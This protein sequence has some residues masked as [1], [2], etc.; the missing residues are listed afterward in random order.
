MKYPAMGSNP[1]NAVSISALS[2]GV[3]FADALN[4][5]DDNQMTDCKNVW[6]KDGVLKTRPG[7]KNLDRFNENETADGEDG[8]DVEIY[9]TDI[10]NFVDGKKHTF[11]IKKFKQSSLNLES[12]EMEIHR[13][14]A[15]VIML[16]ENGKEKELSVNCNDVWDYE[17]LYSDMPTKP[18]GEGLYLALSRRIRT[19]DYDTNK[20]LAERKIVEL[21]ELVDNSFEILEDTEYYSPA[22]L[23]NGKGESYSTLPA[24]EQVKYASSS[25]FE[26]YSEFYNVWHDFYFTTDGVST[27]F[28]LP[29]DFGF[30]KMKIE[31]TN[32]RTSQTHK[33]EVFD[34]GNPHHPA[35][36]EQEFENYV[37][38]K[39]QSSKV[40]NIIPK[41][42]KPVLPSSLGFLANNLKISVKRYMPQQE[43]ENGIGSFDVFYSSDL[44]FDNSNLYGATIST[45]FGGSAE[46]IHGGTRIFLSGIKDKINQNMI[47][48]SDLNNPTYFSENN[49][50]HV[51]EGTQS[52]TALKKQDDMLVIFK[53]N[54]LFYTTYV[55]GETYTAD[56]VIAGKVVD[57]TTL[58]AVF[59]I[60]Q[61]HSEI[62][63]D[64]P[65]SIQLCG[66]RLV[67]ACKDG[68]IYSLKSANQ[69]ST[70]NVA[71]LSALI[72]QKISAVPS[73]DFNAVF[74]GIHNG[75][76]LLMLGKHVFVLDFDH[77]YFNSLPS[78]SDT[79]KAQ[80]K[81]V[82]YYWEFPIMEDSIFTM[83][84]SVYNRCY[85]FNVSAFY[86][87]SGGTQEVQYNIFEL[88]EGL[89]ADDC[90]KQT[91]AINPS[92][93]VSLDIV[94]IPIESVIQTKMFDFGAMDRFKSIEQMYVGF[95][96]VEGET[97][98]QYLTDRG[99]LDK[100][101]V[102]ISSNGDMQSPQFIKTKRFLP[103]I[104]RA[105]RFGVR[106]TAKGR[107][108]ISGVLIK[109]KYM[110]LTR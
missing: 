19:R 109:Y 77:Y 107:V 31:Y 69:Y 20:I 30:C 87:I 54:E 100:G 106:F 38:K 32:H 40:I 82:W 96:E 29:S 23:I 57:V 12:G 44:S 103:G 37:I 51:G 102:E 4:L 22:V 67:W 21:Y 92:D 35:D 47:G 94:P 33:S 99:T 6:Y 56:D 10:V 2:G 101:V 8:G 1:R 45:S 9:S 79:Q 71:A 104:K 61:I 73:E 17:V 41:E 110:G 81:L 74:S 70:T 60:T 59:P 36:V 15:K 25:L 68:H 83:F 90:L 66:N 43:Y 105:L 97:S 76:Y 75:H 42:G 13:I 53:E 88:I 16:S 91:K 89:L 58:S 65:G 49:N 86:P 11:V 24:A 5:V 34:T 78:Y 62:G 64:L 18:N 85:V 48:W 52:I 7:I 28:V 39:A 26:G 80:R 72:D 14:D 46:G 93:R 3:N 27:A 55:K 63:C 50:A 98:V 108:A 95:G 84:F